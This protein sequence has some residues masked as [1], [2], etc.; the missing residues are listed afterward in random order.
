MFLCV[1]E[2]WESWETFHWVIETKS[3]GEDHSITKRWVASLCQKPQGLLLCGSIIIILLQ[4]SILEG[5]V[6]SMPIAKVYS[7]FSA[8]GSLYSYHI[9]LHMWEAFLPALLLVPYCYFYFFAC[10]RTGCICLNEL[11][12]SFS[13]THF[14]VRVHGIL[15]DL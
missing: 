4:Y 8:H 10:K 2:L 9:A 1:E 11:H 14:S 5:H 13:E 6:L 7:V 15:I 3:S 12:S